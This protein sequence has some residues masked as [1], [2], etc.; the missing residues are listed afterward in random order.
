[1]LNTR[2]DNMYFKMNNMLLDKLQSRDNDIVLLGQMLDDKDKTISKYEYITY[3]A[4]GTSVF[5]VFIIL[6]KLLGPYLSKL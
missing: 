1:M 3:Y 5:I 6:E 4:I 2:E